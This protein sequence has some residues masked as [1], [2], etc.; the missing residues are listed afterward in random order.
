[1]TSQTEQQ[2]IT[3]YIYILS[4]NSKSKGNQTTKFGQLTEYNT[5]NIF[6]EKLYTK[7]GREA[8]PRPFCKK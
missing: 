7:C 4:N 8:N 6:L 2:I 1:M 5:R 3:I